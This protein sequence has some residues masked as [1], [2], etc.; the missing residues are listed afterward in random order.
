[1]NKKDVHI[2]ELMEKGYTIINNVISQEEC[3]AIGNRLERIEEISKKDRNK[4]GYEANN[5]QRTLFNVHYTDPKN[6]L[7]LINHPTVVKIV[8]EVLKDDFILSNFN[9]SAAV[10]NNG[11]GD[12]EYRVHIDSRKANPN[13]KNTYQVIVNWC[14]DDFNEKNGSTM[15]L[16]KSHLEEDEP[17]NTRQVHE[18]L[19][20]IEAPKGSIAVVL[21][22]TWHD[23]GNNRTNNRRYGII[24][25]YS[26]WWIKPTFDF[27]DSCTEE[28]YGMLNDE[29]KMLLNFCSRPPKNWTKRQKT[30]CNISKLPRSLK[31]AQKWD[32]Y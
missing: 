30:K 1:M 26:C 6:F 18:K 14:I 13:P 28:I 31:E 8:R 12:Q 21:G 9:A 23:I 7:Y 24:A 10:E 22:Q 19:I 5:R 4:Y 3:L 2:K 25:Y 16:P 32:G 27:V 15:V 29:Q 17:E 20:P 11:S